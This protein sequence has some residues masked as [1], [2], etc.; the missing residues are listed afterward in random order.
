MAKPFAL[1][2]ADPTFDPRQPVTVNG[3]AYVRATVTQI[4]WLRSQPPT[5]GSVVYGHTWQPY[6]WKSYSQKSEQFRH[7]IKGRWQAMNE[8]GGWENAP[9]PDEWAPESAINARASVLP[10]DE[11]DA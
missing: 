1:T 2:T 10:K 3:Y 4:H 8:Y 5:D 6:R 7:G 9:P 11:N